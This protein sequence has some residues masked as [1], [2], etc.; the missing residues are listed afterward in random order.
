[1]VSSEESIGNT[2]YNTTDEVSHKPMSQPGS[3][4]LWSHLCYTFIYV[5][6]IMTNYKSNKRI[7]FI[8]SRSV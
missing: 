2:V 4:E 6:G 1:M 3:T 8:T 5:Q 7:H